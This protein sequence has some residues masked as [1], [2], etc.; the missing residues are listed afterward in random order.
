MAWKGAKLGM[1]EMRRH[2]G[3]YLKGIPNIKP[4]RNKLV[5]AN[6]MEEIEEALE[7]LTVDS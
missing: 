6:S 4:I 1:L 5:T 2:Y 3:N 7:Q